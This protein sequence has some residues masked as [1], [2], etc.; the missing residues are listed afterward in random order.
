MR[1]HGVPEKLTID[2]SAANAVVIKRYHAEHGMVIAI[3]KV[4]YLHNIV[5][6]DHRG[7]KR[8]THPM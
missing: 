3:R 5:E 7:G 4:K 1:R 6:Q 8:L 2:G